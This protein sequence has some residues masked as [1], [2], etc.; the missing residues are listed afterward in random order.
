MMGLT[1]FPLGMLLAVLT[2]EGAQVVM[3]NKHLTPGTVATANAGDVCRPFYGRRHPRMLSSMVKH[4]V[5]LRYF[6]RYR[7]GYRIDH[8]IPRE[9]GG[10][11]DVRNLW[12]Q[13]RD[14]SFMKDR[15]ENRAHGVVCKGHRDLRTVQRAMAKD[16]V[17]ALDG[18]GP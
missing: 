7:R 6:G 12:P 3:P 2:L 8:L 18:M 13:P 10:A 11:D 15:I 14:Q 16:W 17:H 5:Y 1:L 9:L 4:A